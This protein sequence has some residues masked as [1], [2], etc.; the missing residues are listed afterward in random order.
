V[1]QLGGDKALEL[2]DELVAALGRQIELE[3]FD[4][5]EPLMRRVVGA[6]YRPQ[7][8]RTN[9]MKNSIRSERVRRRSASSVSV[10]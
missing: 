3:Q 10:Q 9:L 7:G 5:D 2:G 8:S 4:R 6:K 1:R